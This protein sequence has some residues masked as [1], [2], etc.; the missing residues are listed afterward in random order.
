MSDRNRRRLEAR[1]QK[2]APSARHADAEALMQEGGA[3]FGAGRVA[4]AEALWRRALDL[5]PDWPECLNNLS[6]ALNAL[7]RPDEA[8]AVL[9]RALALRPDYPEARANQ[10]RALRA[11]GRT[12]A[13]I[14]ACRAAVRLAP[15]FTAA[16]LLLADLLTEAA[17]PEA[18]IDACRA[19]LAADPDLL[20]A[21]ARLADLLR[22]LGRFDAAASSYRRLLP[23]LGDARTRADILNRL[24]V[25]LAALGRRDEAVAAWLDAVAADPACAPAHYNLGQHHQGRGDSERAIAEFAA[26]TRADP[27]YLDAHL[28]HA[29]LLLDRGRAAEALAPVRAALAIAPDQTDAVSLLCRAHAALGDPDA[30]EEAARAAVARTPVPANL[31]TLAAA[32][33]SREKLAEAEALC[34]RAVALDPG[35]W[36]GHIILG[37]T[38]LRLGRS[39]EAAPA[40]DA[41]LA[42]RATPLL[43]VQARLL[44]PIPEIIPSEAAIP[45]V[46]AEFL[47]QLDALSGPDMRLTEA[48]VESLV[49]HFYLAYHGLNDRLL[50][51][52]LADF[53]RRACPGL[54]WTAPQVAGW[55]GAAGRRIRVGFA[56][57]L[58]S[59]QHSV[60]RTTAGFVRRLDRSRFEPV[61]VGFGALDPA[62]AAEMAAEGVEYLTVPRSL[63]TARPALAALGL[64]VLVYADIGMEPLSYALGFARLAP[65]QCVLGGHP[66]T[67]G[68]S[69]LDWFVSSGV[70]E[71]ED[72]ADHYT[73]RLALL[74]GCPSYYATPPAPA[75]VRLSEIGL[76]AGRHAYVC[77][78]MLW[79]MHP[80]FDRIIAGILEADPD[81]VVA[82]FRAKLPGVTQ[83]VKARLEPAL[84]PLAARLVWLDP[85]PLEQFMG[86]LAAADAVL[87]TPYFNG[88]NTTYQGLSVGAPIV[89]WPTG[90]MRGR[91]TLGAYR[92][93]GIMDLVARDPADY[94]AL[95]TQLGRDRAWRDALSARIREASV[96]LYENEEMLETF[97]DALIRMVGHA[98]EQ[99]A[100]PA[101]VAEAAS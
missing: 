30:A 61:L 101:P 43:R 75:P 13:A 88:G 70:M 93:I 29:T 89:T 5:R 87:D 85:R 12:E 15:R 72:A 33:C 40:Y 31:V 99:R 63:V 22:N 69:T 56:S 25:A 55:D 60:Y 24:A 64:D 37:D 51:E 39:A 59:A 6:V 18:A 16:H 82:L 50:L 66:V 10:A 46:R 44:A 21:E 92:Q 77:P 8:A 17:Q 14:A 84:G 3:R 27:R 4:E 80:D 76:P 49:P 95:V 73:E 41:A 58:F 23:R 47:R 42:I 57:L 100:Q 2:A 91:C 11:A 96:V 54:D 45:A 36:L 67:S 94:V 38:L 98:R 62:V 35:S 32:L 1:R 9:D 71:P 53:L 79:K 74:P 81:G 26:A 78:Q 7:G 20:E 52:G 28:R 19:A 83:A 90:Q 86:V 97:Q 34:R 68:L 65:V 48:E